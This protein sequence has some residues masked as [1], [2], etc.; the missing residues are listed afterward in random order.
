M[1]ADYLL[2][3]AMEELNTVT[4]SSKAEASLMYDSLPTPRSIRILSLSE[5]QNLGPEISATMDTYSLDDAPPF[6][7][8]SYTWGKP[9]R[10]PFGDDDPESPPEFVQ[11][12]KCNGAQVK[13][14]QN[15]FE[16]L[17]SFKELAITGFLWVDAI[18]INQADLDERSSQVTLMGDVYSQAQTVLV[19]LG[20]HH[21]GIEEFQWAITEFLDLV[22]S[23][24]NLN[25]MGSHFSTA[26]LYD[27]S[28]WEEVY[29]FYR[30]CRWFSRMWVF[31][32][33]ALPKNVRMFCSTT[34]MPFQRMLL[35]ASLMSDVGWLG[36]IVNLDMRT[37]GD[38]TQAWLKE[39][40]IVSTVKKSMEWDNNRGVVWSEDAVDSPIPHLCALLWLSK[41]HSCFDAR[42]NIYALLGFIDRTFNFN[43]PPIEDLVQPDY[44]TEVT[45][46]FTNITT[47]LLSKM[48]TLDYLGDTRRSLQDPVALNLPSWV[49][50]FSSP[51]QA[52]FATLLDR[53]CDASSYESSSYSK[54]KVEGNILHCSGARFD[55][56]TTIQHGN[57]E[58]CLKYN[59]DGL[60]LQFFQFYLNLPHL[61]LGI[62]R[63]IILCRTIILGQSSYLGT[64]SGFSEDFKL[65]SDAFMK[66]RMVFLVLY[67]LKETT[68]HIEIAQIMEA[69]E[70]S[71]SP[72]ER[73]IS[74]FFIDRQLCRGQCGDIS[75]EDN[76]KACDALDKILAFYSL[77]IGYSTVH[78]RLFT[79]GY[80][81]LG[82][83]IET[84]QE[85]DEVWLLCNARA[86]MIL[87]PTEVP[88]EFTL[89]G[90]CYIYGFMDGEM[91]NDEW[92][93]KQN[94]HPIKII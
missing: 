76:R 74:Q 20:H 42:D 32:E 36:A 46:V 51:L 88:D 13:I 35:F 77:H 14:T 30:S 15:L 57:L 1:S 9:Y 75:T 33:I 65:E 59:A 40:L 10:E 55:R 86:P 89:I 92:D 23:P 72:L 29:H 45:T 37:P 82:S 56:V 50:D 83:G 39:L 61:I 68:A 28:F 26:S 85:G 54:F 43:S 64:D 70:L 80:G 78:R 53:P 16:A 49:V 38:K 5:K 48:E 79:M 44:K 47:L 71:T 62:P 81:F 60:L 25:S 73:N 18:C 41:G 94:I 66:V 63:L 58:G 4:S 2:T 90:E 87:R 7:A 21:E 6:N 31:Q 67:A 27:K 69:F 24:D 91:L 3:L 17:S 22:Q 84:L 8:L 12:I 19:W 52:P 11:V 34:E 93:V